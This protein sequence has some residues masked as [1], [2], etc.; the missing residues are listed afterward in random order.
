MWVTL[1]GGFRSQK[2]K[3]RQLDQGFVK[4]SIKHQTLNQGLNET[5]IEGFLIAQSR[6]NQTLD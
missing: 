6:V 4:P 5:S 1:F 3:K 2:E